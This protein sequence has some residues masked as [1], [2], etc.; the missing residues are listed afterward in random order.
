MNG[1]RDDGCW[2]GRIGDGCWDSRKMRVGVVDSRK[3]RVGVVEMWRI[4]SL[5]VRF[6]SGKADATERRWQQFGW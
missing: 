3:R 5:R 6:V 4:S 1:W 2:N